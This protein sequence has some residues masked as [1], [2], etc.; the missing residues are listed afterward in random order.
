[1]VGSPLEDGKQVLFVRSV[2]RARGSWRDLVPDPIYR[3]AV[4]SLRPGRWVEMPP[5]TQFQYRVFETSLVFLV[6]VVPSWQPELF[7]TVEGG[8]W[9]LGGTEPATHTR[10]AVC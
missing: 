6:V 9:S 3:E 8:F 2:F 10:R 5:G 4:T 1:M 7:H